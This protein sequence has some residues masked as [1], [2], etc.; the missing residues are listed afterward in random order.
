MSSSIEAC[1]AV[2]TNVKVTKGTISVDLTD[3]RT[4]I[5]P[6]AWFPRLVHG[7]AGE[8]QNWRLIAGGR[9]IHW[10]ELD[11]DISVANLL[12]GRSSGESQASLKKWL[13]SRESSETARDRAGS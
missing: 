2:A 10:P 6:L 5:A 9:G 8:R 13:S 1:A 12:A 7:S 11:E 3:G 4:I